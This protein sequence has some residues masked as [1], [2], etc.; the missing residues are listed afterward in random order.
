MWVS[1][2]SLDQQIEWMKSVGEI[3]DLSR[4]LDFQQPGR[5]LFAITFDDGWRDNLHYALPVLKRHGVPATIFLATN[6]MERGT[7]L[8]PEDLT[9]KTASLDVPADTIRSAIV[10]LA[11]DPLQ[12]ATPRAQLEEAIE[13]L[14]YLTAEDRRFRIA[15]YYERLGISSAPEEGHML[16]WQEAAELLKAGVTL[17]SH[18]HT[19]QIFS[20]ASAEEVELELSNSRAQIQ[21]H[22][23]F[24]TR[25]FAY[26]NARYR[27]TEGATLQRLGYKHAFR[28]HDL[29]VKADFDPYYI[30][31]FLVSE[32]LWSCREL[33]KL[34]LLGFI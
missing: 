1:P 3:V 34:R 11:P 18:S 10:E 4:L 16:N 22:L 33:F 12:P 17:E 24:E 6:C 32:L 15:R 20:E 28:I 14:K 26:P 27:G 13:Q 23:G 25:R 21:R 30:P 19:H 7:L 9:K 5:T 29:P 31:R 8:W 2:E